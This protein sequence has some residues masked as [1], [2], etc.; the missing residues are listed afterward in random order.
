M[1][2]NLTTTYLCVVCIVTDFYLTKKKKKN[3][4]EFLG[5][6]IYASVFCFEDVLQSYSFISGSLCSPKKS[7]FYLM[8]HYSMT[9][10][11]DP[12]TRRFFFNHKNT[13][14]AVRWM[15]IKVLHHP[16]ERSSQV[17]D[18]YKQF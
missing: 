15:E 9:F 6:C 13:L 16:D 12:Q 11:T 5:A 10:Q 2:S 1:C 14:N 17:K 18:L 8:S 7:P 4:W 3:V